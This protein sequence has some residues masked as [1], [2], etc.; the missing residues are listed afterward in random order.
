MESPWAGLIGGVV[1]GGKEF[2]QA[3][4]G[5]I[6][7]ESVDAAAQTSVRQIKGTLALFPLP[8]GPA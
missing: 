1:L 6:K 8:P 7:P 4:L 5:R 3:L 2:A